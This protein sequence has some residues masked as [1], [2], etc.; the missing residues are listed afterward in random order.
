[1]CGYQ[2]CSPEGPAGT[3]GT[4]RAPGTRVGP[5]GGSGRMADMTCRAPQMLKGFIAAPGLVRPV[6]SLTSPSLGAGPRG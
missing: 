2:W 1:V 6:M 4:T 3:A 5:E